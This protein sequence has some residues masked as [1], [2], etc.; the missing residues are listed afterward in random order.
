MPVE[1]VEKLHSMNKQFS[2]TDG[3]VVVI[4]RE[5]GGAHVSAISEEAGVQVPD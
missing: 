4:F 1:S 2:C 3:F 5:A